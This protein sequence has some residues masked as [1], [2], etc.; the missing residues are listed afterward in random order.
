MFGRT[1]SVEFIFSRLPD[2]T[3]LILPLDLIW[4]FRTTAP[5][6]LIDFDVSRQ[7][8]TLVS[9][10]CHAQVENEI[11]RKLT[12]FFQ[13]IDKDTHRRFE[14]YVLRGRNLEID[15]AREG[16]SGMYK[17]EA[18]LSNNTLND[19]IVYSKDFAVSIIP[20]RAHWL[21]A[22]HKIFKSVSFGNQVRS[23]T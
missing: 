11:C 18:R 4:Y 15:N 16:D 13:D 20:H 5:P 1:Y 8:H 7:P 6:W 3:E 12:H 17:C 10:T 21:G 9:L 14:K 19:P 2:V 23:H 22:D